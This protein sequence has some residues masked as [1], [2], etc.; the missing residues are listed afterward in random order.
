M[1]SVP[2]PT[3]ESLVEALPQAAGANAHPP[4]HAALQHLHRTSLYLLGVAI[5]LI[6]FNAE[7]HPQDR[8]GLD[9]SVP[10]PLGGG[11]TGVGFHAEQSQG[12]DPVF[13]QASFRMKLPGLDEVAQAKPP[14]HLPVVLIPAEAHLA[15]AR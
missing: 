13:V 14:Q 11:K 6:L 1:S 9:Q 15:W 3:S 8:G 12:G 4:S 10:E 7:R 2:A 5:H